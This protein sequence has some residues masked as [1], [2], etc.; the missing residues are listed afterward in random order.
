MAIL[1]YTT[2]IKAEKTAGE[3]QRKLADAKAQAV[4]SE[5]DDHGVICS[6]SFRIMSAN[7]PLSYRLPINTQGV[8]KALLND[9]KVPKRLKT[10]EQAARVALRILKDWIEAQIAIVEAQM[11]DL[12]EVFLPYAQNIEGKTLYELASGNDFKLLTK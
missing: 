3:I 4:M 2:S 7:G 9:R 1:N 11:A 10:R 5:Y 12:K 6:M 8:Y